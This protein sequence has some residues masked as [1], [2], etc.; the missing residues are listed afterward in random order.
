M[1]RKQRR[2]MA[3]K[4]R[5]RQKKM[6]KVEN[7]M[8]MDFDTVKG[9]A[10]N[11]ENIQ[12]KVRIIHQAITELPAEEVNTAKMVED[13][14]GLGNELKAIGLQGKKMGPAVQKALQEAVDKSQG[15]IDNLTHL[16]V[17]DEEG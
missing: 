15:A 8:G 14:Q 17:T 3:K 10:S 16:L 5:T 11:L 6:A 2:A 1:N 9:L 7:Q 4:G 13:L 12:G